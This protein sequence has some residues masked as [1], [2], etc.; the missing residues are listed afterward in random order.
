MS[1]ISLTRTPLS[2]ACSTAIAETDAARAQS[3]AVK[4][5]FEFFDHTADMGL[6]I[7][8]ANPSELVPIAAKALYAAI[9]QLHAGPDRT[10]FRFDRSGDDPA[11]LLRDF[12]TDLLLIFERDGRILVECEANSFTSTQIHV[13]GQSAPVDLRR[14][15]YDREVKA[16]T[17]HDLAIRPVPGGVEATIIVDI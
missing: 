8:A 13:V 14:T 3:P 16:I 6:R 5:E 17:Y 7:R 1:L 12:L 15:L 11:I 9:G 2:I 10:P 4:A